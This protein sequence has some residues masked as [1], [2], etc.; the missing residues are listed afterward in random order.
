MLTTVYN[1]LINQTTNKNAKQLFSKYSEGELY[2]WDTDVKSV[3]VITPYSL[4]PFK[5]NN[6]TDRVDFLF[7]LKTN[8]LY[9]CLTEEYQCSDI[10][11]K[12][13]LTYDKNIN[14][15][16]IKQLLTIGNCENLLFYTNN[17]EYVDIE[18]FNKVFYKTEHD[19]A[20]NVIYNFEYSNTCMY[21]FNNS[22]KLIKSK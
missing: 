8:Y 7:E 16:D 15:D 21:K 5:L 22:G 14:D 17:F 13:C 4:G 9:V 1:K 2:S 10:H 11:Y 19:F 12:I 3:D 20:K 18:K 6:D